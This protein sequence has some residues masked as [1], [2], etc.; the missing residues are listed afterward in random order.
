VYSALKHGGIFVTNT[1]SAYKEENK[2]GQAH[3]GGD[4]H[5]AWPQGRHWGER[6]L[7]SCLEAV[8][9]KSKLDTLNK[10]EGASWA[11]MKSALTEKRAALDRAHRAVVE[12]FERIT[13]HT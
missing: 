4:T 6:P 7:R 3:G 13:G 5:R 1:P 9:A 12:G 8:A 10:A 2:G 11:A